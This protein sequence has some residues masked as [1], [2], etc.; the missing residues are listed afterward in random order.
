VILEVWRK[1]ISASP[2]TDGKSFTGR[3]WLNGNVK[4]PIGSNAALNPADDILDAGVGAEST[5]RVQI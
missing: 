3:I 2:S 4:V 1:L 5:K